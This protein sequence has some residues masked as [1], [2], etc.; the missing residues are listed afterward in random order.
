MSLQSLK[1]VSSNKGHF[2]HYYD[3]CDHLSCTASTEPYKTTMLLVIF[4]TFNSIA[5]L[6]E[7]YK[8]R[9]FYE[10]SS[11]DR[12]RFYAYNLQFSKQEFAV[13]AKDVKKLSKILITYNIQH[14]PSV[15][16][17]SDFFLPFFSL[18]IEM[19]CFLV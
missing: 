3:F 14:D 12:F 16:Q 4:A 11:C 13:F 15:K 8:M 10:A 2:E 17:I 6:R 1:R 9:W 18:K 7:E 5:K 19:T